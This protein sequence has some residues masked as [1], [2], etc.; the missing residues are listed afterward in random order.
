MT[1]ELETVEIKDKEYLLLRKIEHDN[2]FYLYL[3]SEENSNDFIIKKIKKEET[4]KLL[5]LD[6]EIEFQLACTLMLQNN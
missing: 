5:P 2:F 3:A 1:K 4:N 6:N